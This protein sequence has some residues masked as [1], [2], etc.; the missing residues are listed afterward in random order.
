MGR[1]Q[2]PGPPVDT[3]VAVKHDAARMER[4]GRDSGEAT[5]RESAG[6]IAHAAEPN[7][8]EQTTASMGLWPWARLAK[9]GG[10]PLEEFCE[11][12]GLE[13]SALR[14]PGQRFTQ[15]VA[16]RVAEISITR[17]GR[18][19]PLEAARTMEPGHFNLLE[20]IAR[21]ASNVGAGLEQGCRFF[22]LLHDGGRLNF[23]RLGTGDIALR[24]QPRASCDVHFGYV[25]LAFAVAVIGVRR[26]TGDAAL[27]PLRIGFRHGAPGDTGY[28]AR[29]LGV[30]PHFDAEVDE[31]VFDRRDAALPL[32]RQ[33]PEVHAAAIKSGAELIE[34]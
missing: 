15:P 34:D 2:Q 10:V 23:E 6:A 28:H 13:V 11:L 25:E 20:L 16:N 9:L 33:S 12:V 30:E 17:F 14:D 1:P 7:A 18:G 4:A 27:A 22:P 8:Q 19:A 5:A 3:R 31:L 29:V 21:S 26:E 32:S 24:W